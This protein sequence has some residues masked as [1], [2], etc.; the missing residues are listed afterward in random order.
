MILEVPALPV[1]GIAAGNVAIADP[2]VLE[3]IAR[4]QFGEQVQQGRRT[5]QTAAWL[6]LQVRMDQQ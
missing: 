6:W 4:Q 5:L 1:T 3:A 2:C